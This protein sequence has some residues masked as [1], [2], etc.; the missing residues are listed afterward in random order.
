MLFK[1]IIN[2]P[3][4]ITVSYEL[5]FIASEVKT[6]LQVYLVNDEEI[7][8]YKVSTFFSFLKCV[9]IFL[10]FFLLQIFYFPLFPLNQF[11]FLCCFEKG[12]LR[13]ACN[14]YHNHN[15]TKDHHKAPIMYFSAVKSIMFRV[16]KKGIIFRKWT[17]L[18]FN[19][20]NMIFCLFC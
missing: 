13:N 20:L 6:K 7:Q 4:K 5:R 8:P 15:N 1:I 10:N 2:G 3:H 9:K 18:V 14:A 11:I 16:L 17:N 19:L 12:R